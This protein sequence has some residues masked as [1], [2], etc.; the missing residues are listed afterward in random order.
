MR[1]LSETAGYRQHWV[2]ANGQRLRA[3]TFGRPECPAVLLIMGNSAPGLVWPD[4]FCRSLSERNRFVVRFDQRDTGLSSYVDFAASPYTLDHLV[5]DAV[6]LLDALGI[7]RANLVGLSQGGVVAYRMAMRAPER[8]SALTVM[9][10]SADLRPKNDAF[11]GAPVRE[12]ELP[13]PARSYVDAVIALNSVASASDKEVAHNFVENFRLAKGALSPFNEDDWFQMGRAMAALPTLREDRL[14]ARLA[15]HSN[16]SKAQ[17]ATPALTPADLR[18]L[19]LPVQL[20]HGAQ[21]PVFPMPH[22]D[23]AA[24]QIPNSELVVIDR[25]GHAL[26][27][28]FF[29]EIITAM[30]DFWRRRT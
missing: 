6:A 30:T 5:D 28:A 12:G 14:Q 23:W 16:H 26:D 8:S 27:R 9:M 25:M 17:M 13:R 11:T 29:D 4:G 15:N 3:E 20:I 22:A 21:D 1:P 18:N 2:E 19:K 10:S 24:K 7:R